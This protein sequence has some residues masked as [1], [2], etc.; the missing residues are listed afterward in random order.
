MKYSRLSFGVFCLAIILFSFSNCKKD[1]KQP[2]SDCTNNNVGQTI[3]EPI[4]DCAD[5]MIG[6]PVEATGLSNERCKPSCDCWDFTS[7]NFTPEQLN[8]LLGAILWFVQW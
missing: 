4:S 8:S 6:Q 7:K 2:N 1:D 3:E 5:S